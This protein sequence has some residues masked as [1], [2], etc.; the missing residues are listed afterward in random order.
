MGAWPLAGHPYPSGWPL[1][2]YTWAVLIKL[3]VSNER[4]VDMK[5]G[6]GGGQKG[7]L[8]GG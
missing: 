8:E 6:R 4:E 5:L 2:K 1:L 3:G 7:E